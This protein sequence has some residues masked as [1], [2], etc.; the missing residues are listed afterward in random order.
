MVEAG[1]GRT[2]ALRRRYGNDPTLN[3]AEP[4]RMGPCAGLFT[5]HKADSSGFCEHRLA[6]SSAFTGC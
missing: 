3:G 4:N 1:V 6:I 2:V 5:V